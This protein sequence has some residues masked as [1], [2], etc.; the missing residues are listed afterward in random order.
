MRQFNPAVEAMRFETIIYGVGNELLQYRS[1]EGAM[2][3]DQISIGDMI[4][5]AMLDLAHALYTQLDP[6]DMAALHRQL[7]DMPHVIPSVQ[8]K[9]LREIPLG[10][11]EQRSRLLAELERYTDTIKSAVTTG[12]HIPDSHEGLQREIHTYMLGTDT[13]EFRSSISLYNRP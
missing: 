6:R 1:S 8:P 12:D 5:T 10:D 13:Y 11:R 9:Q 7:M 2:L 3:R 4:G